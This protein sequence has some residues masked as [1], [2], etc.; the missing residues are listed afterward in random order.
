MSQQDGA[1]RSGQMPD[2][3]DIDVIYRETDRLYYEV[4]RGCGL[5][6]TAFWSLV[7]IVGRGGE[8][9]QASIAAEYSYSRQ[10]VNSAIKSLKGKNLVRVESGRLDRRSRV[11]T[12]TDE[13][14]SF[15]AE[16]VRPAVE[17]ERRAF[18]SLSPEDRAEFVRLVRTYTD[19]IDRELGK[20]G[21]GR[22]TS[23]LG[24]CPGEVR[25]RA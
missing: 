16:H 2:V 1:T 19:A 25:P 3:R 11:V 9:T 10:T 8:A 12:L 4:A 7:A 13:G 17:A 14:E 21:D 24:V 23:C 5:S 20:L 6:L 15:C 22:G 18:E